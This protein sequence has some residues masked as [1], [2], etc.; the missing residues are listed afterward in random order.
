[1]IEKIKPIV[2]VLIFSC[3]GSSRLYGTHIR[4]GEIV[5][6]KVSAN[7]FDFT[8]IGYRDSESQV[9]FGQGLFDF[10]DGTFVESPSESLLWEVSD[11][12]DGVE[13]WK[14]TVSHSYP[15]A[16]NYIVSY[17]EQNRNRDI[18]NIPGS[19]D[20]EF[21]VETM[22]VIDAL[23]D[24]DSPVFS[25]PPIDQGVVGAVYRHDPKAF[26]PNPQDSLSFSLVTPQQGPSLDVNGYLQLNDESFYDDPSRGNAE[27]TGPPSASI[28]PVTGL[29]TWDAPGGATIPDSECRE[30]NVAIK[31]Q[32]WRKIEGVF[33]KLGYVVRDMQFT[34]CNYDND[35]PELEVPVDTCVIAGDLVIRTVFGTDIN[36]DFVKLEA[37][38]APFSLVPSPSFS[39]DPPQFQPLPAML[40]FEWQ[41]VCGFVR[42]S[43][44]EIAIKATD[45]PDI[46]EVPDQLGLSNF[47]TWKISVVGPAPEGL[48]VDASSRSMH[49]A[50]EP[51]GCPNAD[52]IQIWRRVGQFDF[53]P[54]CEIGIPANSG[55]ELI[56]T[57][58]IA[59]T[60]FVDANGAL[61]LAPGSKY[62]YRLV[63][64]FPDP[65][66]GFSIASE[67][68]CDSLSIDLPVITNVDVKETSE[69]E[70]AIRVTWTP[71]YQI[72]EGG[73]PTQYRYGLI[74]KEGVS[75]NN[76]FFEV[77]TTTDTTF[78]DQGLNTKDS[79]YSYRVVLYVD[80][81]LEPIDTSMQASS[82]RLELAPLVGGI[83]LTWDAN[84]PWSN[85]VQ[86]FPNHLIY[87]DHAL[88]EYPDSLVLIDVVDVTI[89]GYSYIDDGIQPDPDR[90]LAGEDELDDEIEYCYFITTQGS[91]GNSLLPEPLLNSSQVTCA[92]PNDTIP[93][94]IPLS[95]SFSSDSNFDCES[96]FVCG[97]NVVSLENVIE[98][99]A[100]DT[101]ECDN[102]VVFYR[103]YFS[104]S[105]D[106]ST[107]R[108]LEETASLSYTHRN[109]TSLAFCYYITAVDRSNNESKISEVIC[110][111][112][113]PQYILPNVFTPDGDSKDLNNTFRPLERDGQCPRFVESLVLT[114][115][116]RAG[117][118][119][120]RYDSSEV[121]APVNP[122]WDGRTNGGAKAPA[123]IYYYSAE[124]SFNTLNPGEANQVIKGWVQLIR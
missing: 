79:A 104:E 59:D 80:A 36:G 120:Y 29:L 23:I 66:G 95:I 62:C 50:W 27:G 55:Y 4:A 83:E 76:D 46:P 70:G 63:A 14:F 21:H 71:P 108:I 51:Y 102:D 49:L 84:V 67:E 26:D 73:I 123:G 52:S 20:T 22:I 40:E 45:D 118:E 114:L 54:G 15:A 115:V 78:L 30:W 3:L 34:I 42:A 13:E 116:N 18:Q 37:F 69:T 109:L 99:E 75:F 106:A 5:A 86:E 39:P 19:V 90:N 94:C 100:D 117:V 124:V 48:V 64:S 103:V 113:C 92:Q 122:E 57:Q 32:E 56:K 17:T 16:A 82:V 119:V 43:P 28:D 101:Q 87:R 8:F 96:Q 68:A 89:G 35:P 24:N 81:P 72:D 77:I 2:V 97:T 58:A 88:A 85:T 74:R 105:N 12:G 121:E 91:Y 53:D 110:N 9:L 111:D 38:G 60:S 107:F 11:L 7:R 33:Q 25:V 93:P 47:E 41:T 31:V 44:Y 112:N 6:K 65:S 1:M 61:G 10:G 98:W